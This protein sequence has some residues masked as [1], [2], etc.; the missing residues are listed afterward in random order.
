ML[1]SFFIR[2]VSNELTNERVRRRR[3]R[4]MFSRLTCSSK[5]KNWRDKEGEEQDKWQIHCIHLFLS[6]QPIN[7]A[8]PID[9]D[10]NVNDVTNRWWNWWTKAKYN[11]ARKCKHAD[12]Y[13][14]P[15]FYCYSF[16]RLYQYTSISPFSLSSMMW[17]KQTKS[18][19]WRRLLILCSGIDRFFFLPGVSFV[20][21]IK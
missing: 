9:D 18:S 11:G 5:R 7:N 6:P 16:I 3:R 14:V 19:E 12:S 4:N 8:K 2:C 10:G 13:L 20:D 15:S 17:D 21:L 1:Q